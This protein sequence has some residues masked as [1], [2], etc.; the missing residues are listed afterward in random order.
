M[1]RILILSA[2]SLAIVHSEATLPALAAGLQPINISLVSANNSCKV[3]KRAACMANPKC[4]WKSRG[5]ICIV[6]GAK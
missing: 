1:A 6:K 3:L 2:L 5:N 4:K